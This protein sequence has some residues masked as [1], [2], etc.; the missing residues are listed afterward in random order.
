MIGVDAVVYG[1]PLDYCAEERHRGIAEIMLMANTDCRV[2]G[3]DGMTP[4]HCC[5]ERGAVYRLLYSSL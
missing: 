2:T 4:L 3:A 1:T 5:S